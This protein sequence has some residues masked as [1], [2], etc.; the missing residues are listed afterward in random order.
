MPAGS[1]LTPAI[2]QAAVGHAQSTGLDHTDPN[3]VLSVASN[4]AFQSKAQAGLDVTGDLNSGGLQTLQRSGPPPPVQRSARSSFAPQDNTAPPAT[5]DS[6]QGQPNSRFD[7]SQDPLE[8]MQGGYQ[9]KSNAYQ[10]GI[11]RMNALGAQEQQAIS[12]AGRM[13]DFQKNTYEQDR[14]KE[15]KPTAQIDQQ[16]MQLRSKA[17]LD[18]AELASKLQ[19]LPYGMQEQI[20]AK[21]MQA[22]TDQIKD[23]ETFRTT[24]LDDA[25]SKISREIDEHTGRVD[26]IKTKIEGI[27]A[28]IEN[29]KNTGASEASMAQ[30]HIDAAKEELR[31]QKVRKGSGMGGTPTEILQ[32]ALEGNN[33]PAARAKLIA[34]TMKLSADD[35]KK[36]QES[37]GDPRSLDTTTSTPNPPSGGFMGMFQHQ[38]A[39]T[40][41]TT[42]P[43]DKYTSG[44]SSQMSVEEMSAAVDRGEWDSLTPTQQKQYNKAFAAQK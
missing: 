43:L 24:R 2:I 13:A 4:K 26:A 9:A 41:T 39:P 8:E 1:T 44:K 29:G 12:Q 19:G 16:I 14:L 11:D 42:N 28:A 31:L 21:R 3:V 25:K 33:I 38:N 37:G 18:Q 35:T 6:T 27:K 15:M 20:I 40:V 7:F 23:M 17:L 32:I 36:L 5:Q 30:L 10:G 34:R 22:Y